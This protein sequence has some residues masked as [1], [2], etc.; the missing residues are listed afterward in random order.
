MKI[1]FNSENS[2][3]SFLRLTKRSTPGF[4]IDLESS[5]NFAPKLNRLKRF[6]F[7]AGDMNLKLIRLLSRIVDCRVALNEKVGSLIRDE[8][9]DVP[10]WVLVV[11]MTTG[12][13]TA[14]W[15]I[16]APRISSLLRN[17]LDS[18]NSVR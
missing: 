6:E 1:K 15:A 10:G 8:Q 4:R 9:G 2:R 13:V 16:A 12:L 5:D 7:F 3:V 17:S 11:L 18:M 14:I